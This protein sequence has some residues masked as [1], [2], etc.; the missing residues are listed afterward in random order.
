MQYAIRDKR[1]AISELSGALGDLGTLVPL[2]V[3][4]I[5]VNG[6]PATSVFFGVGVA[7]LLTGLF[8]RL[9]IPVQPLKAVAAIAIARG[10]PGTAVA[11]AGWWM[12]GL[13]ILF[14]LADLSRWLDRFFTRPVIRGIQLG[15]GAMLVWSGLMLA[16]RPQVVPGG[17][18]RVIH[19]AS[20]ALPV[21]WLVAVAAL[22]LLGVALRR[23]YLASLFLLAFGGLT[24]LTVGGAGPVLG[25]IRLGIAFPVPA[26]PSTADLL[27]A[28]VFLVLPQI[29]LTLGNAV[30]ATAD[31]AQTYF[32]S[33]ARRVTPRNL[34]TTMGI[35]Q[36]VAALF[37]GVPVCHGSG[38]L[39]AHY[40]LGARTGA[41]PFIMG[42]LC[43]ALALFVDGN[44]LPILALIP[45]PVLGTLLAFVGVQHG[46][47]VRDLRGWEEAGVALTTAFL[48]FATNNLALGFG[49]GILLQQSLGLIRWAHARRASVRPWGGA[50]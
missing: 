43:L 36:L 32:G 6:L 7:Y 21:G 38:G 19:L 33:R 50:Q 40:R 49:G 8:Y 18:E 46:L 11:A 41:A 16:S 14:A 15:L 3:A 13:L 30:F 12:G 29:P 48:G 31:T 35:S 34:L 28:L 1:S 37:G 9:P 39:T 5:T 24:A 22:L 25:G 42:A 45:Y 23:R 44:A 17:E 4:L 2:T 27:S 10:L 20:R 26:L 47:L